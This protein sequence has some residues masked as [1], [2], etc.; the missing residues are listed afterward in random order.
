MVP[1]PIRVGLRVSHVFSVVSCTSFDDLSN[2]KA[3]EGALAVAGADDDGRVGS[4]RYL[5]CV[6][7]KG[8]G[9]ARFVCSYLLSPEGLYEGSEASPGS[10]DRNRTLNWKQFMKIEIPVP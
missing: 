7:I 2:I 8:V 3:S 10:A 6:P 5:T 9:T 4:H 1:A